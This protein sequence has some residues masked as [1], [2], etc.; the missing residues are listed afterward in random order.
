[1]VSL[2]KFSAAIFMQFM[3]FGVGVFRVSD[4]KKLGLLLVLGCWMK[5][6]LVRVTTEDQGWQQVR[7]KNKKTEEY[8]INGMATTIFISDFPPDWMEADLW[9]VLKNYGILVDVF[10]AKKRAKNNNRFG[11]ARFIR[12]GSEEGHPDNYTKRAAGLI[13]P[14]ACKLG[15]IR[16]KDL[17]RS[18]RCSTKER[19][20]SIFPHS[21]TPT[22][23]DLS[24]PAEM[25]LRFTTTEKARTVAMTTLVGESESFESLMNV[26][27]F[28]EVEGNPSLELR[29]V[30]G[31]NTILEFEDGEAMN[32][33]LVE[34]QH[35]WKPWFKSLQPWDPSQKFTKRIASIVIHGVPLHA[36]CEEAFSVI[37]RRWGEV[38]I[39]ETCE[40][41]N[42]NMAYGH[43]GILTENSG[44]ISCA[45]TITVDDV[46]Y[47]IN[48]MEDIFESNRLNPM[49]ACNDIEDPFYH[50]DWAS[51]WESDSTDSEK[52]S[53]ADESPE[54]SPARSE[55]L[56]SRSL[57][58]EGQGIE[59]SDGRDWS[60]QVLRTDTHD[61]GVEVD[62]ARD[63]ESGIGVN[64]NY[65]R[66]SR[67][68]DLNSHPKLSSGL[69]RSHPSIN[70]P[71]NS[72]SFPNPIPST[73]STKQVTNN[74]PSKSAV[75]HSSGEIEAIVELGKKIGFQFDVSSEQMNRWF[76][77]RG[78]AETSQ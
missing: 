25:E 3:E 9:K 12:V 16:R 38:I 35:V 24:P 74:N 11:F 76:G 1:M 15:G 27:A 50:D 73:S 2:L 22:L 69:S 51:K 30:G 13:P 46:L 45:V 72:I 4:V 53:S 36:W 43:V 26:K 49:L 42:L 61:C 47:T 60:A 19:N 34:G 59:K 23:A 10:I 44:L 20:W 33:F 18:F 29:Y 21:S 7:R 17:C 52:A 54:F 71:I 58:S 66:R 75:S 48:V 62:E 68:L 56:P 32:K 39:P 77:K 41:D 64:Q 37:A 6:P 14:K 63:L 8:T 67:S 55:P 57:Q 78:A 40:T 31:L 28:K 65:I 5:L 70:E